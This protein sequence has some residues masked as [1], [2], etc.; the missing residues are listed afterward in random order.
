MM[1]MMTYYDY[2]YDYGDGDGAL[3]HS[4]GYTGALSMLSPSF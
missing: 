4:L 3:N 2:D 1:M